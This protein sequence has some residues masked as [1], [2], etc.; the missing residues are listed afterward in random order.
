MKETE[1]SIF[2]T[3]VTGQEHATELLNRL[4]STARSESVFGHPIEKDGVTVITASEVSVGLGVGF[5]YGG[6]AVPAGETDEEQETEGAGGGGGGGGFAGARPVAVI[7]IK[8]DRV[9]VEPV[10]DPTKLGLAALT[11][12]TAFVATV[13]R[14]LRALQDR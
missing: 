14:V 1:N 10:V 5:G 8:E 4:M 3:V 7:I 12:V 11:M 13:G 6:G 2:T 9:S